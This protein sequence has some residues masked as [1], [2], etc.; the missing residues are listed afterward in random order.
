MA[1]GGSYDAP[2]LAAAASLTTKQLLDQFGFIATPAGPRGHT[3]TLA[4]GMVYGIFRQAASPDLGMRLLRALTSVD[5]LTRMSQ[6]TWQLA[7]HRTRTGRPAL[8]VP[9]HHRHHAAAGRRAPRHRTHASPRSCTH[10]WNRS[11]SDTGNPGPP[12]PGPQT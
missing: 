7:A 8:T 12:P 11:S 10:S 4:G 2:A 9:A 5:A 6:N 1:I 3:A